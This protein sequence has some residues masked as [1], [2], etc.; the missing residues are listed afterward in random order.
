MRRP[1]TQNTGGGNVFGKR[2]SRQDEALL[3]RVRE[4]T[5]HLHEFLFELTE[6]YVRLDPGG[7]V[8]DVDDSAQ[9]QESIERIAAVWRN[10]ELAN[11]TDPGIEQ[12]LGSKRVNDLICAIE[13]SLVLALSSDAGMRAVAMSADEV[14][15]RMHEI[16]QEADEV[17]HLRSSRHGL[18]EHELQHGGD[19]LVETFDR[20]THQVA[21]MLEAAS[22]FFIEL[23]SDTDQA[24]LSQAPDLVERLAIVARE[25]D[26]EHRVV[27]SLI[28]RR[29]L[30]AAIRLLRS[31]QQGLILRRS[32]DPNRRA[33]A[34]P[35]DELAGRTQPVVERWQEQSPA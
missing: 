32:S 2:P 29:D 7:R 9:A 6:D 31:M 19:A 24:R 13:D 22:D 18:S 15:A 10:A 28:D 21:A 1:R 26:V 14:I 30:A 5:V 3:D 33:L 34:I 16:V 12:E 4:A 8:L 23:G 20:L 17:P 27:A 11:A 35:V 25:V